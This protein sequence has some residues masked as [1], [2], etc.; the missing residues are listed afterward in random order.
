[1]LLNYKHAGIRKRT[2]ITFKYKYNAEMARI[3]DHGLEILVV[4]NIITVGTKMSIPRFRCSNFQ[5]DA[6]CSV[7]STSGA[8]NWAA[9]VAPKLA[10]ANGQGQRR[11]RFRQS[12]VA[13]LLFVYSRAP[14]VRIRVRG[15]SSDPSRLNERVKATWKMEALSFLH[16]KQVVI[17]AQRPPLADVSHWGMGDVLSFA[18]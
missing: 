9:A 8:Q 18:A 2:I 14:V 15:T 16:S 17:L 12:T 7:P 11:S 5:C 13:R 1:M 10:A 3:L 4:P 6:A